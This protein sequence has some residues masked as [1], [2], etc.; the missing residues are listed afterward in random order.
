MLESLPT[1]KAS[2]DGFPP[3]TIPFRMELPSANEM[4]PLGHMLIPPALADAFNVPGHHEQEPVSRESSQQSAWWPQFP[5]PPQTPPCFA[6]APPVLCPPW[7]YPCPTDRSRVSP[8]PLHSVLPTVPGAPRGAVWNPTAEGLNAQGMGQHDVNDQGDT[9][10]PPSQKRRVLWTPQMKFLFEEAV[11]QLGLDKA[12]PKPILEFMR[13]RGHHSLNRENVASHLQK[14][15]A[16]MKAKIEGGDIAPGRD[17]DSSVSFA[18][19]EA[20][21][22]CQTEECSADDVRKEN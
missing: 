22:Q 10:L 19:A 18:T 20:E 9:R 6:V 14:Y 21:S 1:K 16:K 13:Q 4:V 7:Y 15:R 11:N 3:Q 2:A 17:V 8:P 5:P 12:T